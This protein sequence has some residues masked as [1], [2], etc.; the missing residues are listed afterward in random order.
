M[1]QKVIEVLS[2]GDVELRTVAIGV[3]SNRIPA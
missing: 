2:E 3:E 1:F